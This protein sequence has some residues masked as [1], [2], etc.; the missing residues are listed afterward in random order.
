[1]LDKYYV[2]WYAEIKFENKK[3]YIDFYIVCRKIADKR[4]IQTLKNKYQVILLVYDKISD[5][6]RLCYY[7]FRN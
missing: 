7:E 2:A 5:K 4:M 6:T 3:N 1:M